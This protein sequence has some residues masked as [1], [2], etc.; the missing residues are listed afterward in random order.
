MRR[1]GVAVGF[2][3]VAYVAACGARSDVFVQPPVAD[4]SDDAPAPDASDDTSD[5]PAPG[6]AMPGDDADAADA[7]VTPF[8]V[9]SVSPV[10]EMTGVANDTSLIV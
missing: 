9:L 4:A 3:S 10:S 8:E 2:L 1:L 7:P 5:G 6:D